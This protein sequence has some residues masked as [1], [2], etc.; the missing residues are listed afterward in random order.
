M[1][2]RYWTI[3]PFSTTTFYSWIQ[4][5]VTFFR[6]LLARLIPRC[7]PSSKLLD[8]DDVIS[9]TRAT[10]MRSFLSTL[11]GFR[12]SLLNETL[13]L[14]F[15]SEAAQ[16]ILKHETVF[17]KC[18]ADKRDQVATRNLGGIRRPGRSPKG[19]GDSDRV[20]RIRH[21]HSSTTNRDDAPAINRGY[22]ISRS[23]VT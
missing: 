12:S 21:S 8:E 16:P 2:T 3:L 17:L 6:V 22:P 14:P 5:P 20:L 11:G 19:L 18:T 10:D 15:R 4:A 13:G 1:F 23:F 9:V 7:R